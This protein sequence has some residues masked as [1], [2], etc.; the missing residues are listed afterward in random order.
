MAVCPRSTTVT[1]LVG[2]LA[3]S[4]TRKT[5]SAF[6]PLSHPFHHIG[7]IALRCSCH[8]GGRDRLLLQRRQ[9]EPMADGIA[10]DVRGRHLNRDPARQVDRGTLYLLEHDL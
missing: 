1:V 2:E 4:L 7:T 8:G 3:S 9:E 5:S 6:S 10:G